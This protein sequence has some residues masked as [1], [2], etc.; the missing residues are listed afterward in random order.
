[1]MFSIVEFYEDGESG[2]REVA[3]VPND[4]IKDNLCFWPHYKSSEK[5]MKAVKDN[6]SSDDSWLRYHC[7]ILGNFGKFYSSPVT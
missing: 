2:D 5:I 3:V 1:M 7:R 4:W 6:V